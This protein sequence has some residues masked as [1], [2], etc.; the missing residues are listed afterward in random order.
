MDTGLLKEVVVSTFALG[1]AGWAGWLD[2]RFRRIPNWL[3][4][5]ALVVGLSL[6]AVLWRWPGLKLS[7]EGAGTC[8]VIL[9]PFVLMRGLGAGDW[10][11]M[12]ALGAFLGPYR[13]IVVLL[14]TVLI[15]GIMSMVEVIRQRK[16]VET[17][18]N[19]WV[20][21]IAYSTFH[22]NN[23]HAISLDNPGLL[24][25]PFGVAAALSTTLFLAAFSAFRFLHKLG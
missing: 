1:L 25:I 14:G 9:L 19:L 11:L 3:T 6:S 2:W 21:F 15:A 16:V 5:P 22:V 4:V 17:L 24:K 13:V 7:L 23:A 20:L 8:L 12:G 10:K 18:R